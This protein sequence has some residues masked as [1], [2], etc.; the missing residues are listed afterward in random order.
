[1]S[2]VACFRAHINLLHRDAGFSL[3]TGDDGPE[4]AGARV[5]DDQSPET[6]VRSHIFFQPFSKSFESG[7]RAKSMARMYGAVWLESH[8]ITQ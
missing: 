7:P 5:V 6:Q 3:T 2:P 4:T 8:G 1:M